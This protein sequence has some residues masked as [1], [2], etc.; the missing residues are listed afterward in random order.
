M[1]KQAIKCNL[2]INSWYSGENTYVDGTV[3]LNGKTHKITSEG[4]ASDRG[5]TATIDGK[6]SRWIGSEDNKKELSRQI[7]EIVEC[8][9]PDW[10]DPAFEK[11]NVDNDE[12]WEATIVDGEI[13]NIR[14]LNDDE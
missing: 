5:A 8:V 2:T 7:E 11:F 10:K 9:W 4:S 12:N 13:T 6:K 1:P 14:R 3:T